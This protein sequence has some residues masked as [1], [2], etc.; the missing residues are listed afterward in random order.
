M[1]VLSV[2]VGREKEM[3]LQWKPYSVAEVL[4]ARSLDAS[5]V[6]QAYAAEDQG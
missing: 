6:A 3:N 5:L 2:L 1:I 4:G